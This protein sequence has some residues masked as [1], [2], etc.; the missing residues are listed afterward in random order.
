MA[1]RKQ[2]PN[3]LPGVQVPSHYWD[4]WSEVHR[5]ATTTWW[6]MQFGQ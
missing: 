2:Y 4:S 5:K 6:K 3:E 1:T